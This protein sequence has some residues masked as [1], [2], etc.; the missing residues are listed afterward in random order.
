MADTSREDT[1]G[2]PAREEPAAPDLSEPAPEAGSG[3]PY[4]RRQ[5]ATLLIA[6]VKKLRDEALA[7]KGEAPPPDDHP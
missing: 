6:L 2:A 1:S 3:A 5:S 4:A 7:A